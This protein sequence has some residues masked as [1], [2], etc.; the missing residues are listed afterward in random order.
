VDASIS[1][2]ISCLS[3]LI[4]AVAA[5]P[6]LSQP[7]TSLQVSGVLLGVGAIAVIAVRQ[8]QPLESPVE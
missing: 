1:S 6:I 7:L 2:A 5:I 8:R 3:P 4:S